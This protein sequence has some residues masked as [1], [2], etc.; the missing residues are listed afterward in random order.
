MGRSNHLKNEESFG[1][2]PGI[3]NGAAAYQSGSL[4]AASALLQ[5]RPGSSASSAPPRTPVS[6]GQLII[7]QQAAT[8]RPST[9]QQQQQQQQQQVLA[10]DV[11][12]PQSRFAP[13]VPPIVEEQQH[14][15]TWQ[16]TGPPGAE[17]PGSNVSQPQPINNEAGPS[18]GAAEEELVIMS[19]AIVKA[20][21]AT[22]RLPVPAA[23]QSP[24][25]SPA[26][27][28]YRAVRI[29]RLL[30][31][32]PLSHNLHALLFLSSSVDSQRCIENVEGQC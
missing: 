12:S 6:R 27:L 8:L 18:S 3:A 32:S 4:D 13:A 19:D 28:K 14:Q 2:A 9:A 29:H 16:P 1:W 10:R 30:F 24:P 21:I 7:P 11:G 25:R 5:R 31:P 26:A 22:P 23:D 20:P 15:E 17:S